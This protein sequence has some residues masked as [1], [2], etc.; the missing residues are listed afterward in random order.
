[1]LRA[2]SRGELIAMSHL[3]ILLIL[4][5]FAGLGYAAYRAGWIP[6]NQPAPSAEPTLGFEVRPIRRRHAEHHRNLADDTLSARFGKPAPMATASAAI[7]AAVPPSSNSSKSLTP[8]AIAAPVLAIPKDFEGCW[9]GTVAQPDDWTFGR[10]PIV[11]GW[12]PA[13]HELC[14]HNSGNSP[15][16]TFSTSAEYPLVSE[17]VVPD[18][19]VE[20]GHAQVI[21][22]GD[23]F[24]VLRTTS[25]MPLNM[26]V[27]GFL[28]GPTG[29]ITSLSDLHCTYLPSGKLLVEGSTVQRCNNAHSVKCDGDV[30]IRQSW[31]TEFSRQ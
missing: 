4:A 26:K 7:V 18:N 30:W 31:H 5:V 22:S 19:G 13:T 9:A 12:T 27:L 29:I 23:N 15:E 11:K 6:V 28:P 17:W 2:G 10:G 16:V 1:M 25:S 24:V 3:R 14:F 8:P 21:F 20:N